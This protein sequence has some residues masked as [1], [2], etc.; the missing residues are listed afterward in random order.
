M[1]KEFRKHRPTD[2]AVEGF[3]IVAFDHLLGY[4]TQNRKIEYRANQTIERK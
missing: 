3:R 4:V 1:R 2:K